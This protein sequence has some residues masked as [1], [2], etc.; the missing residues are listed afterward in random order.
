MTV[1]LAVSSSPFSPS[2]PWTHSRTFRFFLFLDRSLFIS[3]S[4]MT[5]AS[6][7]AS[8]TSSDDVNTDT[9]DDIQY[10]SDSI[11]DPS[12]NVNDD[13]SAAKRSNNKMK[14]CLVHRTSTSDEELQKHLLAAR[15]NEWT[16]SVWYSESAQRW[17]KSGG[18]GSG[19]MNFSQV[20]PVRNSVSPQKLRGKS[21]S[22]CPWPTHP[23]HQHHQRHRQR[24][25]RGDQ[26]CRSVPK[27]RFAA[28]QRAEFVVHGHFAYP[29][30]LRRSSPFGEPQTGSLQHSAA[31]TDGMH[32]HLQPLHRHQF[33][34]ERTLGLLQQT[35]HW[36]AHGYLHHP[37]SLLV[38][39][40]DH[41]RDPTG[42]SAML[43]FHRRARREIVNED[44]TKIKQ[45][46]S[47][48]RLNSPKARRRST[49]SK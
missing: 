33:L 13:P 29:L 28:G 47:K 18:R 3:F 45:R 7:Q 17:V 25:R 31:R 41:R 12:L 1:T 38:D 8:F 46:H 36:R 16:T 22:V 21:K 27:Q 20:S 44:R 23:P 35:G 19:A 5:S 10:D 34:P 39:R 30:D 37:E 15:I 32:H 2:P 49:E 9:D 26:L 48:R 14:P 11:K 42:H 40:L 4:F 6:N 24:H 43:L